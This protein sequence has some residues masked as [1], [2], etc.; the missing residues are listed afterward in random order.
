MSMTT[1]KG[2]VGEAYVI[3]GLLFGPVYLQG[4][5]VRY[6]LPLHKQV[7]AQCDSI[8]GAQWEVLVN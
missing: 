8:L 2:R 3:I 4:M 5:G 1:A 6:L 7:G